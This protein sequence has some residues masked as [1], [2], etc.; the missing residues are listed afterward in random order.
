MARGPDFSLIDLIFYLNPF[1]ISCFSVSKRFEKDILKKIELNNTA[2]LYLQTSNRWLGTRLVSK[3]T[4][5]INCKQ[6]IN[7]RIY[8]MP[9]NKQM[10]WDKTSK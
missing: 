9:S 7:R 8:I 4:F 6:S 10:T 1:F 3:V 2:Y 5:P